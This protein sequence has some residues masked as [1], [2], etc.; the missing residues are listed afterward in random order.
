MAR[1]TPAGARTR[2]EGASRGEH[3]GMPVKHAP[4]GAADERVRGDAD[5]REEQ[6]G[7]EERREIEVR[8]RDEDHAAEP[9]V[10]AR[11][12][13]DDRADERE[14]EADARA[15][16]QIGE[17]TRDAQVAEDLSA[18]SADRLEER[19]LLWVRRA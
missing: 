1:T 15:R 18:R 16:E 8:V 13:R 3:H 17:S 5:R 6:D 4:L 11:P 7:G 19:D 2:G 14:V 9:T 10:G 12:F